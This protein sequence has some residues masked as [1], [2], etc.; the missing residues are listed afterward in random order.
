MTDG[1]TNAE[2]AISGDPQALRALWELNRR[3]IAAIVLAH[4]PRSAELEDLLQ[5]VAVRIVRRVHEVR[6]PATLKP[7]MRAI[8]INTAR[9]AGRRHETRTR[10]VRTTG[11]DPDI[12]PSPVDTGEPGLSTEGAM[13]AEESRR[14]MDAANR[15]PE[16]YREP[17]L[18]RCVRGM[19]YKQIADLMGVPV[20]TVETR[21]ARARRM[22]RE[23]LE[24]S[25][26]GAGGAGGDGRGG[27]VEG[28]RVSKP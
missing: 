8:A 20:T 19:S 23:E 25:G 22:V 13:H 7:W 12:A 15:L 17:L 3:W 1:Y 27:G 26:S 24:R 10:L 6:D 11:A 4:K 2:R 28:R 14:A 16:E 9:T 21:L 18:L 5:E